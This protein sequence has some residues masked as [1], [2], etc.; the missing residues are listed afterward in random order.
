MRISLYFFSSVILIGLTGAYIHTLNLGNHVHKIF[1][2][3][4]DL[5]AAVWIV[6]P[7]VVLAFFS[8]LHMVYYSMM[9]YLSNKKW[10]KD[11]DTLKDALYWSLLKEPK[12]HKYLTKELRSNGNLFSKATI[13]FKGST[14]GMSEKFID[15]IALIKDIERGEYIDLKEKKLE[16]KLSRENP[17][18][19]KNLLNRLDVDQK[20]VEDVLQS[21]SNQDKRVVKKA[22]EIFSANE[23]FLKA[24]KYV[25][26]FDIENFFTMVDRAASGEDVGMDEEV[27][28]F[29][30]A[31]LPFTCR[32]YMHLARVCVKKFSPDTNL[33]MFKEFRK[34]D[35]NANQSYLYLLF[36]YELLDNIEEFLSEHGESDYIRFRALFTLK[37][38][39]NKYNVENMVSSYA[40]CNEN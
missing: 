31:E 3:N 33:K 10:L 20:Y 25:K 8:I 17:I 7:M 18:Y 21:T 24:K 9:N 39:N 15:I 13:D 2:Q 19:V 28:K 26:V 27:L 38:M 6:L 1:G 35:E 37:K 34:K 30:V 32:E 16:K 12:E 36:E 40:V 29:F 5:P 11:T 23:T 14:E 22:L 4:I